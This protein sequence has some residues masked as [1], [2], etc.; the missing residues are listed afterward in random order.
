VGGG[1]WGCAF[2]PCEPA[3]RLLARGA[4]PS[5]ADHCSDGGAA[6]AADRSVVAGRSE[7]RGALG[8]GAGAGPRRALWSELCAGDALYADPPCG[9][10]ASAG[11]HPPSS[12]DGWLVA[13][14]AGAGAAHALLA[15]G[16]WC[17]GGAWG[18]LPRL[19]GVA[20]SAGMRPGGRRLVDRFG[21]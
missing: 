8:E 13:A 20:G 14:C 19:F 5:G 7:P 6:L 3:C 1:G 18:G 16:G 11:A 12:A 4:E 2:A 15:Q 9:G 10:S 17:G 21:G